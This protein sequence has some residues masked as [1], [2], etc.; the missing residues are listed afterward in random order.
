[1]KRVCV[2]LIVVL[3]TVFVA[4]QEPAG[5][6]I[7]DQF[8]TVI[9]TSILKK[10]QEEKGFR[11][12]LKEINSA[13][14]I[15]KSYLVRINFTLTLDDYHKINLPDLICTSTVSAQNGNTLKIKNINFYKQFFS[16]LG[17]GDKSFKCKEK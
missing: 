2:A 12:K 5:K 8:Q 17:S 3:T 1:M 6:N 15:G 4:G 11:Y 9:S 16:V 10:V 7:L 14:F 13:Y